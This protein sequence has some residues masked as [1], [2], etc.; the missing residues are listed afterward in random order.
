YEFLPLH[1]NRAQPLVRSITET[2][3]FSLPSGKAKIGALLL[4]QLK[5]SFCLFTPIK[6]HALLSQ[7]RHRVLGDAQSLIDSIL[8][9]SM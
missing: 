2:M 3:K 9:G 1:Q 5:C 7:L 8:A 4:Q 6:L